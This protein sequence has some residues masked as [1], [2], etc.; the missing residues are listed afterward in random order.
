MYTR[1][2]QEHTTLVVAATVRGRDSIPIIEHNRIP[3]SGVKI[4]V[5]EN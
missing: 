1:R 3:I 4:S 5:P 2:M